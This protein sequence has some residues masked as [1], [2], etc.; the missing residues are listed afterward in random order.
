[1]ALATGVQMGSPTKKNKKIKKDIP[2]SRGGPAEL[3]SLVE[4]ITNTLEMQD[5]L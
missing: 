4:L 2:P 1:M 5:W 3:E